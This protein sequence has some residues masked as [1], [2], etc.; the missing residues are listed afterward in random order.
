MAEPTTN[1]NVEVD[2][3]ALPL[4]VG[5]GVNMAAGALV[6]CYHT[7]PLLNPFLELF[8]NDVCLPLIF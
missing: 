6:S 7:C 4:G 2:Y 8:T 3:E 1:G 5:L